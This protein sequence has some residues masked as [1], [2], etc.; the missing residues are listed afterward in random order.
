MSRKNI[1]LCNQLQKQLLLGVAIVISDNFNHTVTKCNTDKEGRWMLLNIEH[2]GNCM[3]LINV[4]APNKQ[5]DRKMFFNRCER[6]IRKYHKLESTIL[7]GGDLNCCLND[8]DRH[9]VT[10][11]KDRSRKALVEL[12]ERLDVKDCWECGD[13]QD[14]FTWYNSDKSIKSR[15]DYLFLSNN[16]TSNVKSFEVKTVITD[17]IGKRISDHKAIILTLSDRN[18]M[19]GPGYWK[20]NTEYLN[21]D[22]FVQGINDTVDTVICEYKDECVNKRIM[23]DILKIRIKEYSI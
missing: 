17:E 20:L 5:N 7:L 13:K 12:I 9:P 8:D 19:R 22:D 16:C 14:Q 4:Y 1:P 3:S 11:L 10:H 6:W 2:N 23:W 18:N 21:N 15:L